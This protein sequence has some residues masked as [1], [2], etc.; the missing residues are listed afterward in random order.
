[1]AQL[2]T[3]LEERLMERLMPLEKEKMYTA[4]MSTTGKAYFIVLNFSCPH[5]YTNTSS[6]I[7]KIGIVKYCQ[8]R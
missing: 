1:M 3:I 7:R 8:H 4:K 6:C 2:D 5:L